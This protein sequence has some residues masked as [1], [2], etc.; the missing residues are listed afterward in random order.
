LRGKEDA[1]G[2]GHS[3]TSRLELASLRMFPAK[4]T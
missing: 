1:N 4:V 3:I 2:A